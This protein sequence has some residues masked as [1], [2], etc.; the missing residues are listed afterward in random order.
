MSKLTRGLESATPEIEAEA[1]DA[2]RP[3]VKIRKRSSRDKI[4]AWRQHLLDQRPVGV[5]CASSTGIA[6][7]CSGLAFS[8]STTNL[9]ACVWK[10]LSWIMPPQTAPPTWWPRNFPKSFSSAIPATSV[11]AGEQPGCREGTGTLPVLSQQR[12]VR[13]R[14]R[15]GAPD[16]LCGRPARCRHHWS[17]AARQPGT[18]S[19]LLPQR[20]TVGTLLHRTSLLRWTDSGAARIAATAGKTSTPSRPGP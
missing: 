16:Y 15:P 13:A 17:Q 18:D 9:K 12:Y 14:W 2:H 11:F 1:S 6:G 10:P 7:T 4:R 8:R 3:A 19:S 5:S 20:P